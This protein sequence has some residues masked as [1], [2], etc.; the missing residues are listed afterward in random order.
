MDKEIYST[1]L[2][3]LVIF[4][5]ISRDNVEWLTYARDKSARKPTPVYK[6]R[7]EKEKG[8]PAKKGPLFK[9]VSPKII[10][11]VVVPVALV[12]ACVGRFSS[13]REEFHR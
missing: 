3:D 7:R 1:D 10:P 4:L 5:S 9:P 8:G 12:R 2:C 6:N 11:G 13:R